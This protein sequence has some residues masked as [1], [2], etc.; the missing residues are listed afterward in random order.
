MINDVLD[1]FLHSAQKT[2]EDL[3]IVQ[4]KNA[5]YINNISVKN[6]LRYSNE[7]I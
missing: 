5:I 4:E 7:E 2:R 1:C 3:E 6:I